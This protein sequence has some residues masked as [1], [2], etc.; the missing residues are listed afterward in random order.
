MTAFSS[1]RHGGSSVGPYASFNVN[2]YCGDDPEHVSC[3]RE[4]LCDMLGINS[5]RLVIPHQTHGDKVLQ[6]N[7]EWL[8]M[9]NEARQQTLEGVD[10]LVTHLTDV[11]IGVS[12][13]DCIP[14]LLYDP[15]HHVA[16]A[17][18]AGWR[19]TVKRIVMKAVQRMQILYATHPDRICAIVGPGISLEAF[20][21]GCEVYQLFYEA[22][23]PM[24]QIAR[25]FP[26]T[27]PSAEPLK[28]HIDLPAC[29]IW[30]L[31]CAGVKPNNIQNVGICTYSHSDLF[32]SARKLSV[33]SGRILTAIILRQR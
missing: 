25:Q 30:Q 23:F 12:T 17:V 10:A 33:H 13:A 26:A 28:W 29:N 22:G 18:H 31:E 27:Q 2:H 9:A 4:S 1:T 14:L 11:C 20:E 16:A 32:F 6:I 5:C 8:A 3:N 15:D 24:Q 7:H 21:V 19:G